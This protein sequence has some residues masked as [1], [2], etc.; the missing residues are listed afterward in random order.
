MRKPCITFLQF[1]VFLCLSLCPLGAKAD[2]A[3]PLPKAILHN[4]INAFYN[5]E[6]YKMQ[7][8]H[9]EY[10]KSQAQSKITHFKKAFSLAQSNDTQAKQALKEKILS[11]CYNHPCTKEQL[12]PKTFELEQFESEFTTLDYISVALLSNE[13]ERQRNILHNTKKFYQPKILHF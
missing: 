3:S 6:I 4:I 7:V 11:T 13:R 1:L 5:D 9:N 10:Y 12:E 8:A 2:S